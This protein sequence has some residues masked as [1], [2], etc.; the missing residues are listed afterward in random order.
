MYCLLDMI[1]SALQ[2]IRYSCLWIQRHVKSKKMCSDMTYIKFMTVV[3][4]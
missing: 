4:W 3:L 1:L 2:M